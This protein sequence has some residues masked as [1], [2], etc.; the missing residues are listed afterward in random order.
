MYI[1]EQNY[2]R[3]LNGAEVIGHK[4]KL[5]KVHKYRYIDDSLLVCIKKGFNY[6]MVSIITT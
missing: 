5:N 4:Q 1:I 2:D 6:Y 3:L